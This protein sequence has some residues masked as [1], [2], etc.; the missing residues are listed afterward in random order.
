MTT[1][2]DTW[3]VAPERFDSPDAGALWRECYTHMSDSWYLLTENRRTDPEELE[4]EIAADPGTE[5]VP[6]RGALVIARRDGAAAGMAGVRLL[7]DGRAE[8]KRVF[9]RPEFR[10][11]GGAAVLVQAAE[12]QARRLGATRMVL[13]TRSDFVAARALYQR[14]GY[15][16]IEPY[17]RAQYAEHWY[18]KEL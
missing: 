7:D 6:P 5:L 12:E 8:L 14:L 2:N 15:S 4:R 13:E 9:L 17:T 10:G 3:T 11:T 16:E 1:V 18:G